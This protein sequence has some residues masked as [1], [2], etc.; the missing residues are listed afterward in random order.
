MSINNHQFQKTNIDSC[1]II[2]KSLTGSASLY[3]IAMNLVM[4]N[5][6]FDIKNPQET[7][8]LIVAK[9]FLRNGKVDEA[10]ALIDRSSKI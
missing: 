3:K 6:S 1:Q 2:G 10:K 4:E 5:K 9:H 7:A 8:S